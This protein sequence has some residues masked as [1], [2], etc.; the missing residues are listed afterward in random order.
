MHQS[1]DSRRHHVG[2][3][4]SY[5]GEAL[6]GHHPGTER[7]APIM[8]W[9][10]PYPNVGAAAR[11]PHR[12]AR[13]RNADAVGAEVRFRA[14]ARVRRRARGAVSSARRTR[15]GRRRP[16]ESRRPN[17]RVGEAIGSVIR[18]ARATTAAAARP[19]SPRVV[20]PAG[21]TRSAATANE[22]QGSRLTVHL[23]PRVDAPVL[24]PRASSTSSN[25]AHPRPRPPPGGGT[26]RANTFAS[27][28]RGVR[29]PR[30]MRGARR[31]IA[32]PNRSATAPDPSSVSLLPSPPPPN[33]AKFHPRVAE[34]RRGARGV[35]EH[36][37]D[38]A[39][40]FGGALRDPDVGVVI[41]RVDAQRGA[42]PAAR[43]IRRA[44]KRGVD[45]LQGV[46]VTL[47]RPV[48]HASMSSARHCAAH[49]TR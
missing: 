39:S 12:V 23:G 2:H 32:T 30:E 40:A 42:E 45:R 7:G 18:R 46:Q 26:P 13:A 22:L 24:I 47:A 35:A 27:P 43:R 38:G 14:G 25:L 1:S 44:A 19:I 21:R 6:L 20:H 34:M 8:T 11:R 33:R 16:T 5:E 48:R 36:E 3:A 15:P 17:A 10:V 49:P 41:F 28:P 37:D 9:S 31:V 29:F 4:R